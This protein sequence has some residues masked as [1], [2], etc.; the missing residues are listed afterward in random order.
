MIGIDMA[1]EVN[2]MTGLASTAA[3]I[4]ART[5][6]RHGARLAIGRF[7]HTRGLV[8]GGAGVMDLV[9]DRID[10]RPRC[11][12]LCTAM[13]GNAVVAHDNQGQMIASI[14]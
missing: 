2:S 13:T 6:I 8:T 14:G 3:I 9:I 12:A 4:A 5:T 7:Q 10:R 1:S 11:S